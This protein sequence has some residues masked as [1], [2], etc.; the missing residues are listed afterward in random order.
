MRPASWSIGIGFAAIGLGICVGLNALGAAPL[1]HAA[2]PV[3]EVSPQAATHPNGDPAAV[4]LLRR[5][6]SAGAQLAY[7]GRTYVAEIG[8]SGTSASTVDV[9][10]R[11]G[12]GT[13]V[14]VQTVGAADDIEWIPDGGVGLPIASV[15][16]GNSAA[17]SETDLLLLNYRIVVAG[18]GVIAGRTTSVAQALRTDGSVAAR[19]EFDKLTGLM[20]SRDIYG[21]GHLT[22]T[23]LAIR[24]GTP[25]DP[26]PT[27]AVGQPPEVDAKALAL[28][29][30]KGWVCRD[31]LPGGFALFQVRR[32]NYDGH[33]ALHLVY[34]DGLIAMSLF[35]Q[36]GHLDPSSL[37]GFSQGLAGGPTVWWRNGQPNER[38]WQS[39]GLVVTVMG[40]V[41]IGALVD[42]V[43]VIPGGRIDDG[44]RVTDRLRR[45]VTR[46][47]AALGLT[48]T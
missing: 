26:V 4:G 47:L 24:F 21:T 37:T 2:Q 20:L 38:V 27:T 35:Q 44:H 11:P 10:H 41:P 40:D 22:A 25:D 6:A 13:S 5:A 18:S 48:D 19:F 33:P 36:T 42:V 32:E 14:V 3:P 46:V 43:S 1:W 31:A 28:L 29:R 45:G 39:G 30:T 7:E 12:A 17:I 8:P 15:R 16:V 23:F 9:V 34:S